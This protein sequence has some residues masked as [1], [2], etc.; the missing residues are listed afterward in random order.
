MQQPHLA[1]G[2]IRIPKAAF[3]DY[4]RSGT[5]QDPGETT[6]PIE[7]KFNPW[8][9]LLTGRFT[10]GGGGRR[11]GGW[12]DGG[13]TGG[14]GGSFGGAGATATG[15]WPI[16]K[17]SAPRRST[18]K[19][20]H[21]AATKVAIIGAAQARSGQADSASW[22]SIVRNGYDY[23]IDAEDRTRQV[24]GTLTLTPDQPRSRTSQAGAGGADRLETDDGGHYVARRFNGPT[25]AF[26]HFAQDANFNRGGYRSL[27]NEWAKDTKAGKKVWVKITPNYVGSSKRPVSILVRFTVD[28]TPK[29]RDFPNSS[30]GKAHGKR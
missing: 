11:S 1:S 24:T 5:W 25:E 30:K 19:T 26:N 8:H 17:P 4:L 23:R 27:E 6:D 2:R 20:G 9:D 29:E 18:G 21:S 7:H 3:G 14:G 15:D 12:Q 22:H 16:T 13:F 10:F 28:G